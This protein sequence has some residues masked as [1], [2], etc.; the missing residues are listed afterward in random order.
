MGQMLWGTPIHVLNLAT[1]G[2]ARCGYRGQ[3]AAPAPR[4]Q[5][6]CLSSVAF[7]HSVVIVP[8]TTSVRSIG[9]RRTTSVSPHD[10]TDCDRAGITHQRPFVGQAFTKLTVPRAPGRQTAPNN[11]G[12]ARCDRA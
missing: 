12:R 2:D 5:A 6:L 1:A 9:A 11:P 7:P 4:I 8:A 3:C 10:L